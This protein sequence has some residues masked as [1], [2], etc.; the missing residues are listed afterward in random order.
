MQICEDLKVK[1]TTEK[2][3]NM[4]QRNKIA[5][6][7]IKCFMYP[8]AKFQNKTPGVDRNKPVAWMKDFLEVR[9]PE[10]DDE[11]TTK[12]VPIAQA[13]NTAGG[14]RIGWSGTDLKFVAISIEAKEVSQWVSRI[15]NM[16]YDK[17]IMIIEMILCNMI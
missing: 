14:A 17:I 13:Y 5:Q 4:I 15:D 6:G 3:L 10:V 1:N 12:M 16:E 11:E 2:Y 7:S 9:V 8:L